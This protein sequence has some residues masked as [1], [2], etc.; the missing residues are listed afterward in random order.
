[1][2]GGRVAEVA[3][4]VSDAPCGGQVIMTAEAMAEVESMQDMIAHVID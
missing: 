1:M 3:K 4:W 2:Y